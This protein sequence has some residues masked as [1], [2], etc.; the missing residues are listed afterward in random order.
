MSGNDVSWI[1]Q[2]ATDSQIQ[3]ILDQRD[4]LIREKNELQAEV[5]RLTWPWQNCPRC[6]SPSPILHPAI[7]HEGEVQECT[8]PFHE[9]GKVSELQADRDRERGLRLKAEF[10]I[11]HIQ[12]EVNPAGDA[13]CVIRQYFGQCGDECHD[14]TDEQ[15][16]EHGREQAGSREEICSPSCDKEHCHCGCWEANTGDP[17]CDCYCH[18]QAGKD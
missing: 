11:N 17:L 10:Y 15:W 16:I 5:A 14:W 9:R 1:R 7:Q 4:N 8:H 13:G 12:T 2:Q 6:W 3:G 18:E